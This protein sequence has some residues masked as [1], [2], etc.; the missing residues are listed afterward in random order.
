MKKGKCIVSLLLLGIIFIM[1]QNFN[2]PKVEAGVNFGYKT[3]SIGDTVSVNGSAEEYQKNYK[4]VINQKTKIEVSI[5]TKN[6][7][8]QWIK[9]L[10]KDGN[11]LIEDGANND[12]YWHSNNNGTYTLRMPITLNKG[13][14]Y[15]QVINNGTSASAGYTYKVSLKAPYTLTV[16]KASFAINAGDMVSIGAR[17]SG[18]TK[19]LASKKIVYSS[20]KPSV[21]KVSSKGKIKAV[22]SGVATIKVKVGSITK[23]IKVVVKPKKINKLKAIDVNKTSFGLTW[24]R[25]KNVTGYIVYSYDS[26]FNEYTREKTIKGGVNNECFI[27]E[28]TGM[29]VRKG[30]TYKI[31]VCSYIKTG[32]KVYYGAKSKLIT[33]NTKR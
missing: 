4:F 11:V 5:K 14:Y 30:K 33:V 18:N 1:V 28:I 7:Y 12:A 6:I 23:N 20:T 22:D 15:L 13:V 16:A 17:L 10:D 19:G 25:Q 31:K 24:E 2:M 8:W 32:S 3:I 21:A 27:D 29:S 9:I 26:D